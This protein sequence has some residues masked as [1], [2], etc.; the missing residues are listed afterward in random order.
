M[1]Y[2]PSFVPVG[3]LYLD[4][5]RQRLERWLRRGL[6]LQG[7][8]LEPVTGDAS[9]RRYFRLRGR[10]PSLIA[11][12]APPPRED[13]G[14]FVTAARALAG[15]GLHVPEIH[16][17][18]LEAGF[19]LL[20]DL[21]E[22]LYSRVLDETR[23][24]RLYGDALGALAALQAL[25]P[26]DWSPPAY[27][28]PLLRRELELFPEWFLGRYLGVRLSPGERDE[29]EQAFG[30]LEENAL[31][32]PQVLVHRDFHSRNL[33]YCPEH[34]PGILD[35]QDAVMGPVTYD[36]VSLL[37]DAYL[38]WPEARVQDW[39]FGYRELALQ[40][41]I[42]RDVAEDRFWTWFERMGVQRHLKVLGIFARLELRDGRT[43]YRGDLPRVLGYLRAACGR[44][45]ALAALG[46]R[47]EAVRLPAVA[48]A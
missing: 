23:A 3:S 26:G 11:M 38:E 13:A 9:F 47:L 46:A 12:D 40:S 8:A 24:D 25:G 43:A 48:E 15:L 20:E 35:F 30:L 34:N 6:G 37:R 28:R 22:D 44:D 2:N 32:Q 4:E 1:E 7:F 19:V 33:V 29:L 41:G 18:D 31:E 10:A 17:A 36:L 5:R 27:D 14:R 21:G 42:L 39:V 45:P 16:A